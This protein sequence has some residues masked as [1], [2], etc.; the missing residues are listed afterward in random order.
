MSILSIRLST[1][2]EAQLSSEADIEGQPKSALVRSVLERYVENRQRERF[3]KSMRDA[4]ACLG[5][6]E[7]YSIAQEALPLDN[8]SLFQSERSES[9]SD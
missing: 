7:S 8:E 9:E 3:M 6:K 2:L 4:A 1:Q 5:S